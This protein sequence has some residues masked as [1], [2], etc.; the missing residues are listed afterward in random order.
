MINYFSLFYNFTFLLSILQVHMKNEV[1]VTSACMALAALAKVAGN[2]S[3]FGPTGAVETLVKV[4]SFHE[5]SLYVAKFAISS[6]GNLCIVDENRERL[7]QVHAGQQI[8]SSTNLHIESLE[9]AKAAML[10]IGKMCECS[11]HPSSI[12]TQSQLVVT[13]SDLTGQI[14]ISPLPQGS[15][16]N[17]HIHPMDSQWSNSKRNSFILHLKV[18]SMSNQHSV[19][20]NS[21]R[22]DSPQLPVLLPNRYVDIDT[23]SVYSQHYMNLGM[24]NRCDF[25]QSN[26]FDTL[27]NTLH[28]HYLSPQL[29]EIVSLTVSTM[30]NGDLFFFEKENFGAIGLCETIHRALQKHKDNEPVVFAICLAIQSLCALSRSNQERFLKMRTPSLVVVVLRHFR[31]SK[32]GN[33]TIEAAAMAITNLCKQYFKAK[34]SFGKHSACEGLL[35]ALELFQ[36]HQ[37]VTYKLTCALFHICDGSKEN[38]IKISFLGA[39]DIVHSLLVRYTESPKMVEYLL[40]TMISMCTCKVGQSRLGTV[41]TCKSA[42]CL[43][44]RLQ[45]NNNIKKARYLQFITCTLIAMLCKGSSDNQERFRVTDVGSLLCKL[46]AEDHDQI[47]NSRLP[48][49]LMTEEMLLGKSVGDNPPQLDSSMPSSDNNTNLQ[50]PNYWDEEALCV[51]HESPVVNETTPLVHIVGQFSLRKEA[52]KAV[53]YFSSKNA[54]VRE[55]FLKTDV[56]DRLTSILADLTPRQ[57]SKEFP[58][59]DFNKNIISDSLRYWAKKALDSLIGETNENE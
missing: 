13:S 45:S 44:H 20:K 42:V 33:R 9:L 1:V 2:A 37:L 56:L 22:P 3:W 6:M 8:V 48:R 39:A 10:T 15:E 46:L 12:T 19:N 55:L 29:T 21:F 53:F 52:C 11:V 36:R 7:A 14:P 23:K 26:A 4:L 16:I 17:D 43:L 49:I 41:G 47:Q 34:E 54:Q 59:K 30:C 31:N 32:S 24:P 51:V 35:E 5:K 38:R 25:L 50:I 58:R 18:E 28:R 27:Y 57:F 40:Y